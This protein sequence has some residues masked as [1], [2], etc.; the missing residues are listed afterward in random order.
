MGPIIA[1]LFS[2]FLMKKIYP[3]AVVGSGVGSYTIDSV[4]NSIDS[5]PDRNQHHEIEASL[6]DSILLFH[7]ILSHSAISISAM[8]WISPVLGLA[9]EWAPVIGIVAYTIFTILGV[10]GWYRRYQKSK[11][12]NQVGDSRRINV[13][14]FNRSIVSCKRT[15]LT[16]LKGE[17]RLESRGTTTTG[18]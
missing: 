12:G 1:A 5:L 13:P 11:V 18:L 8:D 16:S 3:R 14:G 9:G 6:A 2:S 4:K 10:W 15:L 7:H 17:I